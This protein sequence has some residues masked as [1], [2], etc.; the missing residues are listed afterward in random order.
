MV[1]HRQAGR[2]ADHGMA[3]EI[4]IEWIT[5]APLRAVHAQGEAAKDASLGV[6]E[7]RQ[8]GKA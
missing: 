1:R 4:V 5:C 8:G 7:P 6:S 3:G 2:H